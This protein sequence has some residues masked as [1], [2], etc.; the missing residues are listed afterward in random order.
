VPPDEILNS[1]FTRKPIRAIFDTL[2]RHCRPIAPEISTPPGFSVW[3][4]LLM[5]SSGKPD[6]IIMVTG[7]SG[8]RR[9][10]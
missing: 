3:D 6:E 10:G 7:L 9:L 8:A 1:N 2:S 5:I 4:E